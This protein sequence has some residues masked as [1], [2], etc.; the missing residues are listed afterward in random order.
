MGKQVLST[1]PSNNPLVF[2]R[3]KRPSLLDVSTSELVGPGEYG[4]G[5]SA[6]EKQ[7]DSRKRTNEGTSFGKAVRDPHKQSVLDVQPL[8]PGGYKLPSGLCGRGSGYPYRSA[9]APSMSGREKF[10][11]PF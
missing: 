2:G 10:G 11:S 4:C 3:S 1:K 9:P 6:C 7:V 5:I 8:G